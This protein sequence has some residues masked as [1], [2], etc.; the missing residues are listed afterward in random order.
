MQIL[1]FE[2]IATSGKSTVIGNLEKALQP[3]KKVR[4][5]YEDETHVPIME[6]RAEL[7]LEFFKHLINKIVSEKADIAILDR[8]YMTQAYRA[9]SNL[10][11]YKELE[12]YLGQHNAR[13]IFLKV[14][15]G[16]IAERIRKATLHRD[17]EWSEYVKTHGQ[18]EQIASYY[19]EQQRGQLELLEQSKLPYK[20][21][22]TTLHDYDAVTKEILGLTKMPL[23]REAK[24]T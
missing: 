2:G 23:K 5:A 17:P 7:H 14:D 4:V 16:G 9:K 15:E 8:L 3:D 1:I 12:E 18:E 20:I 11:P 21:F 24:C 13:T 22:D 10:G 6:A 19:I